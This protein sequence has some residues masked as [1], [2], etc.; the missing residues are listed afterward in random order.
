MQTLTASTRAPCG[1]HQDGNTPRDNRQPN[2]WAPMSAGLGALVGRDFLHTHRKNSKKSPLRG[3]LF[4]AHPRGLGGQGAKKTLHI[5]ST[6]WS[7]C[8]AHGRFQMRCDV[9]PL[10]EPVCTCGLAVAA[11]RLPRQLLSL[12]RC[13]CHHH[14]HHHHCCCHRCWGQKKSPPA[15]SPF[16][17]NSHF[18]IKKRLKMQGRGY[19][20]GVNRPPTL[21]TSGTRQPPTCGYT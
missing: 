14:C 21:R 8:A 2:R 3:A 13:H 7:R 12:P 15:A 4:P 6:F 18:K 17:Q 19:F 1:C 9:H 5:S 11:T 16:Y 10:T 20:G